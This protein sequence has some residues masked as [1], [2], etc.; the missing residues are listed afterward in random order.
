MGYL[1]RLDLVEDPYVFYNFH[2][3]EPNAFTHQKA[4]FS[5]EFCAYRH[6]LTYPG[7]M[8]DYIAFL[9]ANDKFRK[10]HPLMLSLIHIWF[11]S[12]YYHNNCDN[13]LFFSDMD[14]A[15]SPGQIRIQ[16][17]YKAEK[18]NGGIQRR[19]YGD[20]I[21]GSHNKPG[22]YRARCV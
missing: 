22:D 2:Y 20:P 3:Y 5:E 17:S 14:S 15:V 11:L 4:H 13:S 7:D 21:A 18:C 8:T 19:K 1:D 16:A 12:F 10:E 9:K 6:T